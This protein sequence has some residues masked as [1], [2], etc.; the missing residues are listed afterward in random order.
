[1]V[2]ILHLAAEMTK[3][4]VEIMVVMAVLVALLVNMLHMVVAMAA[5]VKVYIYGKVALGKEQLHVLLL[6]PMVRCFLMEAIV[7]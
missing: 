4:V 2:N 5:M 7:V 6:K 1:M 3:Q